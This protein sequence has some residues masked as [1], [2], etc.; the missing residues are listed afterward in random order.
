MHIP[1]RSLRSKIFLAILG[2]LIIVAGAVM[3]MTQRDVT[4]TVDAGERHAVDNVMNLVLRDAEARW[5]A[6]LDDKIRSVRAGRVQLQQLSI[7]VQSVL[8]GYAR[9]AE[10]GVITEG[11]A[12]GMAR[13]WINR[14]Q[15]GGQRYAFVYDASLGVLASGAPG[16]TDMDLSPVTDIKNR[17]LA[18]AMYEES[19]RFAE[20]YALYRWPVPKVA[21]EAAENRRVETRYAHFGYFRPWNWVV[22]VSD[23][24]QDILDQVQTQRAQMETA[25]RASLSSL[26]LARSG[27]LFILSDDGHAVVP[28]PAGHAGLLDAVDTASGQPLREALRNEQA[29]THALTVNNG[30]SPWLIQAAYHKPL[31]WTLAAAVPQSDLTAPAERLI[32]RQAMIFGG[33][34]LLALALAWL[35]ATRIT[36]PLDTLTGYARSLPEQDLAA[37]AEPPERIAS[38]PARH[39]DEVG[40]LAESFVFMQRKLGENVNRLMQETSA[41]ERIE[42]ELNIARDIQLGLLPTPLPRAA[43]DRLELHAA[44]HPAKEVGGDLYDYFM[45]PD[46]RLCFAIGDV[47]GKGVPAALFMAVTRTLIRSTAEDESDPARI[48]QRVNNRL[49]EN[50]PNMMFVTLLLGVLDLAT[51]ELAWANAGHPPPAVVA[52]DGSV[53]LLPGRSGPACGVQEDMPYQRLEARLAPGEILLGYTDGVTDAIDPA[54]EQYGEPRMLE[55]LSRPAD[56]AVQAAQALLDDVYRHAAGADPFDDITLI[57]IRIL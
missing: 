48:V 35:A 18:Q 33:A 53:R 1:T 43:N 38:L 8:A 37:P 50:N 22:A 26:T 10:R 52:A 55:Q 41:R 15:L 40:R 16:M 30:G 17:P 23:D 46:G 56:G 51:G 7:T 6:L 27:F 34:V 32:Q 47:S 28:V 57:A 25:M 3:P 44:M 54:G 39:R 36:R 20:G 45:L 4:R 11:S 21:G 24:A 49:S 9:L 42:S 2:L 5:G 14:L 29:E 12:K 31:G 19:S 13:D